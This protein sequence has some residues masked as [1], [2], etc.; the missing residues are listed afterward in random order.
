MFCDSRKQAMSDIQGLDA[1]NAAIRDLSKVAPTAARRAMSRCGLIAVREAKANAPKSP[2]MKQLSATLKR[3]KRTTRRLMPGGLERS[4]AYEASETGCSVFVASNAEAGRYAK[5]IHDEKG[6]TWRNR[7][8][9]TIAKGPRA[10]EKFIE[11]AIRDNAQNFAL[12]VD[13][14]VRKALPK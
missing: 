12:I 8:P 11:R 9:G 3:K 1:V 14:E 6:I 4:I 2:T 7:G 5:R 10:D 13:D